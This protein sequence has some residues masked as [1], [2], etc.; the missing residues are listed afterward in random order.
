MFKFGMDV[1]PSS[2][3]LPTVLMYPSAVTSRFPLAL[4]CC[5]PR[6]VWAS[7]ASMLP[8][9]LALLVVHYLQWLRVGER[10]TDCVGYVVHQVPNPDR[11]VV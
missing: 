10:Q 3:Q 1:P 6:S 4:I 9:L 5:I 2:A 11:L 8:I 7:Y